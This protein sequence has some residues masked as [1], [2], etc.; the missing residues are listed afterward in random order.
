MKTSNEQLDDRV[1]EVHWEPALEHWRM[2]RFRDDKPHGNH[3]SV[4]DNIIKSIAD[5]IEKDAVRTLPF[6][7]P[8]SG[9]RYPTAAP[10]THFTLL[11]SSCNQ[12][13]SRS[14]S[15]RNN[16]K[17][18]AVPGGAPPPPPQK[19]AHLHAPHPH[20][21]KPVPQPSLPPAAHHPRPDAPRIEQ[22]YSR[23]APSPWSKV[24]G[25]SMVG[26]MYR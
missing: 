19:G 2:M 15:I 20:P 23:L 7:L 16:W 4:V 1:V 5:G 25:P 24:T 26:G 10:L 6:F 3:K 9:C 22:R 12:L 11:A 8:P 14:A 13:L 18:R 17:A 21:Q